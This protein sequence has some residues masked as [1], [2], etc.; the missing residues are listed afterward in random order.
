MYLVSN[1]PGMNMREER[2]R[3]LAQDKRIRKVAGTAWLVPSQTQS[4]GGYVVDTTANKCSCPDHETRGLK[5]KHLF[6]VEFFQR[7]TVR[8]TVTEKDGK[9]TVRESTREVRLTYAQ[10]WPAYNAAQT[11][12][13]E[14]AGVLLRALL[15]GVQNPP[16]G[17]GRPRLP[18]A[19]VIYSATLKV[20][21][22]MSGRRACS[23]VRD[24]AAKGQIT[25]APSYNSVFDYL[26]RPD[27]T[28]LLKALVEESAAPLKAVERDFAVDATGFSTSTYARWFDRKYGREMREQR[29]VK[30]HA[31][32]GTVT[33]AIVSVEVTEGSA[34][35]SPQLPGLVKGAAR[36]GFT[37]EEV[38]ADKGYVGLRNLEAI[39]SVG[40]TPYIPFKSNNK[41][42]GAA[43]WQRMWHLFSYR[44]EEFLARY[45]QRSNVESTFSA[46]KRKFGGAVRAKL[47]TAQKNEVLTKCLA[48]NLSCLVHAFH[49]LG[50]E[51][52]FWKEAANG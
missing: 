10:N 34:N 19:D 14:H 8:E 47:P 50:V 42:G 16:Q 26:E 3:L 45:H 33:N 28:P 40:A 12:E 29:W 46:V 38:S 1:I 49:E 23:D 36:R 7:E 51:S 39:E 21:V 30:C 6:A 31:M 25:R 11:S 32:V 4:T 20:Y 41:G 35:D 2:G 17:R 13:R 43:A 37:L 5:C 48:F 24:C 15:E 18:L 9:T 44:R 27:L 22:G 52:E